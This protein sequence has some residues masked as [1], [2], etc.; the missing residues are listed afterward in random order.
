MVFRIYF[1]VI[2]LSTM[3]L[4]VTAFQ[5]VVP[6]QIPII[7]ALIGKSDPTPPALKAEIETVELAKSGADVDLGTT[8]NPLRKRLIAAARLLKRD[9]CDP[10][11]FTEYLRT[12]DTYSRRYSVAFRNH[13]RR[14]VTSDD[15]QISSTVVQFILNGQL[16]PWDGEGLSTYVPELDQVHRQ[17]DTAAAAQQTAHYETCRAKRREDT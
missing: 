10:V 11:I 9:P 6:V 15:R 1:H 7:S 17:M 8:F 16:R 14:W 5:D 12:L 3:T 13:Q 4:F 2:F